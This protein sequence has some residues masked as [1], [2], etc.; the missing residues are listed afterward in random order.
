MNNFQKNGFATRQSDIVDNEETEEE[1]Q[2]GIPAASLAAARSYKSMKGA[3]LRNLKK[4]DGIRVMNHSWCMKLL[5]EVDPPSPLSPHQY[6]FK[7]LFLTK[8]FNVQSFDL[9]SQ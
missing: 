9:Y 4:M 8:K 5:S 3:R 1:A 7:F 6:F 2:E